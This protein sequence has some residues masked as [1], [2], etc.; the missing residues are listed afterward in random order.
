MYAKLTPN[1]YQG[2]LDVYAQAALRGGAAGVAYSNTI[3]NLAK[4][5]PN[6]YPYPQVGTKRISLPS[7]GYSGSAIRPIVLAGICKIRSALNPE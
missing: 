2:E 7:N 3:S 5:F 4:V 6:G 1:H